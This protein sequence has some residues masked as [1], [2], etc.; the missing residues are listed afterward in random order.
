MNFLSLLHKVFP[1]SFRKGNDDFGELRDRLGYFFKDSSL[2]KQA[3]TH[4]SSLQEG[5]TSNERLEFLGDSILGLLISFF[6]YKNFPD[7]SEG[8]LTKLK[9]TLVSEPSLNL[10]ASS[11]GLGKYIFLS[12]EEEKSGGRE[13]ASI[14]SDAFEAIIG[15]IFLDGGLNQAEKVVQG[16]IFSRF[17]DL[18][19]ESIFYN[20]KGELLEYLQA[21]DLGLPRYEVMEE[22]G[23]DHQKIFTIAV[24]IKGKKMG[25]GKGTSKKDAEQSAAKEAL[26]RIKENSFHQKPKVGESNR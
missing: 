26:E 16:Q 22:E 5:E 3:L 25:V 9:A 6:L 21:T 20:Y 4:R 24:I 10:V 2:L 15:A 17:S 7:K 23:P 12:A 13:K 18:T 1:K 11:L 8:E 19:H 14:I